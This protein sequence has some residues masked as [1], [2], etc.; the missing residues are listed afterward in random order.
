MTGES[1]AQF[2][3]GNITNNCTQIWLRTSGHCRAPTSPFSRRESCS[4]NTQGADKL[5]L[6]FGLKYS[7][8]GPSKK[9]FE[10]DT[11]HRVSLPSSLVISASFFH[12]LMLLLRLIQIDHLIAHNDLFKHTY[13]FTMK[14]AMKICFVVLLMFYLEYKLE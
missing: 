6:N 11:E 8:E 10:E 3:K 4:H 5:T 14:C 1:S 2:T 12:H 9:A 13:N 7:K